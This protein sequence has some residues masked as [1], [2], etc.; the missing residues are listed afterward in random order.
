M[1]FRSFPSYQFGFQISCLYLAYF[2]TILNCFSLLQVRL[3]QV[4]EDG[5]VDTTRL[6]R[7]QGPVHKLAVEPGS[8]HILYS[9]G[10]DGFV[11]H[12]G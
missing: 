10:E 11:Q 7:H 9:C 1:T 2:P 6:G 4:W 3:G 12:V 5:R 8:P